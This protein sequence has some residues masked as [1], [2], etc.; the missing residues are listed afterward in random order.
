M[1]KKIFFI[2]FSI[3]CAIVLLIV[4]I[5]FAVRK[6]EPRLD[7]QLEIVNEIDYMLYSENN[8][9]GVIDKNGQ[10]I[11]DSRY[12]EIQIP[13]PSK[14]LFICMYGYDEEK[15]QYNIKVLNDKQEQILYQYV[16]VEAIELNS[17]ISA[18]PYEKSVLKYKENGK[19]GLIDFQGNIITKAN[20]DEIDSFDYN[21][22]LL[23]VKKDN[24]YGIIN[25]N[26]ATI[27]KQEYDE[28]KSDGYY[29]DAV[30]YRK[31]GYIVGKKV[32]DGWKYGY[33]DC[34]GKQILAE[35]Y[36][37]IDRITNINK[38]D[39][40]YLVAFENDKAG[41]YINDKNVINHEYE[42]I[43]YDSNNNCLLLQ[44]NS[45]QGISDLQGNIV[46]DIKYD[47]IYISGK[48]INAQNGSTI[49]IFDYSTNEK[50][51]LDNIVGLN[52]TLNYDYAIAIT[53]DEKH[54]ILDCNENELKEN[55]Y[56]YLEYIYDNYFITFN[57]K[58][59]GIVDEDGNIIVG[60]KYD[61]IQ[62]IPNSEIVQAVQVEK[63][64]VDL[65]SKDRVIL[66]MQNGEVYLK[67]NYLILQSDSDFKYVDYEGNILQS[68]Q[69]LE[70]KLY[71]SKQDG[72]WG[73]TNENGEFI[74][75]AQYDFVTEF[76]EYGFAGIKKDG[77]W[78]VIDINGDII[79][80][81]VY[82]I[83]SN[84][85]RFVGKYYEYNLGY[86]KPYFVSEIVE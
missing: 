71:A 38:N 37:Q 70:R 2:S 12:D 34:K 5:V 24:K 16:I 54:K 21:E 85:P 46:L 28:I 65:I 48:Y 50:I 63:N 40:I 6:D 20:Y 55:E 10:V 8:K 9:F 23:R 47:N 52:Q 82:I 80:E 22:G 84:S 15:N 32:N 45:K 57:N 42:D 29:E 75:D 26:G 14:P 31:S 4:G 62:K 17:G 74:V 44:K 83:D 73:F 64:T 11:I 39:D 66:T 53:K 7:Y 36:N 43:G 81:P 76:N 68:N 77:K 35:K 30:E 56:D 79:V 19:Y 78:G 27:V 59:F 61:Y 60:F 72:K 58:K 51:E 69:V 33:I 86:G 1:N 18:I 49:E 13:N 67:D 3:I 25:I 41:F